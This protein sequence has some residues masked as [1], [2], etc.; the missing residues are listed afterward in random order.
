MIP[1]HKTKPAIRSKSIWGSTTSLVAWAYTL[2][3]L[4]SSVPPELLADT[5]AVWIA[6]VGLFGT[7]MALVGRWMAHFRLSGIFRVK[8]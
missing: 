1:L 7:L 8:E 4:I 5:K 2:V 3:E 6:A